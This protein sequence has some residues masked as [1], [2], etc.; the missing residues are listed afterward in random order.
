MRDLAPKPSSSP[1]STR[2]R[3]LDVAE[4]LFSEHG[5]AGVGLREVADRAELSKSSLF[6]HFAGKDALYGAVLER[7]LETFDTRLARD[8][9]PRRPPLEQVRS[10]VE[11]VVD[12]LADHPTYARLLLRALFES[13]GS[14]PDSAMRRHAVLAR[15]TGR[16]GRALA[17]GQRS[18]ALRTVGVEDTM[19]SVIGMTLYPLASPHLDPASIPRIR[20]HAADFVVHALEPRTPP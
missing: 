20:A 16:I 19:Q 6:H 10:W 3:I 5:F 11:V 8:E 18:G 13:E 9:D 15:I 17:R 1:P 12:T 14:D 2:E 7:L 4:R